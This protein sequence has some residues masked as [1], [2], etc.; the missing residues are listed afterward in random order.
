M[1]LLKFVMFATV[2]AFLVAPTQAKPKVGWGDNGTALNGTAY[3][4]ARGRG[5]GQGYRIT[6]IEL[7]VR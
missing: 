7:P 5:I 4:D 3:E 6:G 2:A 1:T